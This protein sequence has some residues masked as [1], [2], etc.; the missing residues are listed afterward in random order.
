VSR[1][2][3]GKVIGGNG[4]ALS[5]QVI[6]WQPIQLHEVSREHGIVGVAEKGSVG[7]GHHKAALAPPAL[8]Q[9][10]TV[11]DVPVNVFNDLQIVEAEAA[12]KTS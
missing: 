8:Q 4:S 1:I 5:I 11:L 9:T 7:I 12:P 10:G 3:L 6:R 2:H